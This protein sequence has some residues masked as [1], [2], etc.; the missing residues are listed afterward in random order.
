MFNIIVCS[1][2]VNMLLCCRLICPCVGL[3]VSWKHL[4]LYV[5]VFTGNLG[6]F[7]VLTSSFVWD[8]LVRLHLLGLVKPSK[9]KM[10]WACWTRCVV[11]ASALPVAS[12][13]WFQT[14]FLCFSDNHDALPPCF[15]GDIDTRNPKA[16]WNSW[17]FGQTML[18]EV[19]W[20]H[21]IAMTCN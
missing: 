13:Y 6:W 5:N 7:I 18:P 4:P 1:L 8:H 2:P 11:Q 20:C 16:C 21:V 9:G 3:V 19:T 14:C 10:S 15:T 17:A 12:A